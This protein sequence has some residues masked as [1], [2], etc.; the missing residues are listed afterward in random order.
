MFWSGQLLKARLPS[1]QSLALIKLRLEN[2]LAFLPRNR[3]PHARH[4]PAQSG[5]ATSLRAVEHA[6]TAGRDS[7]KAKDSRSLRVQAQISMWNELQYFEH[8]TI[9]LG[10]VACQVGLTA[11]DDAVDHCIVAKLLASGTGL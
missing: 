10:L 7:S 4:D 6:Q 9:N 5:L 1:A 3:R 2:Y 8:G 11:V